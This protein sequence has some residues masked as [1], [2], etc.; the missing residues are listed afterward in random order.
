MTSKSYDAA[1]RENEQREMAREEGSAHFAE[2][3]ATASQAG[4]TFKPLP[5]LTSPQFHMLVKLYR[6]NLFQMRKHGRDEAWTEMSEMVMEAAEGLPDGIGWTT[7][8]R[9]FGALERK[10]YIEHMPANDD[11]VRVSE[12]AVLM[13]ETA[14]REQGSK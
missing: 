5:D 12:R 10:G 14:E 2:P 1:Y 11:L 4:G 7:A 3:R 9:I 13:L 6:W 8:N